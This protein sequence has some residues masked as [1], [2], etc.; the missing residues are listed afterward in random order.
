MAVFLTTRRA[1]LAA[2]GALA[3]C[4]P[5]AEFKGVDITGADYARQLALPDAD[6]KTRT[7]ADWKGKAVV[8]FF[9]FTQC[10]D[11]CPT[12]LQEVAEVKRRL[13]ADGD[14]LQAVF[15]T[16]DPERDTPEV[17]KGYMANF[18]KDFVALRGTP[19]E[20]KAAA[21]Q[22]KIYYAKSPGKAEGSYSMDHTAAS[23]LFDPQ[24][25]ARVFVRYGTGADAL[26][27]DVRLL[28]KGA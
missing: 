26:E 15:V 12:T 5:Q 23:F 2:A 22:F 27:N 13:G 17:L 6:G 21:Q 18:G 19:E 11:V 25:R 10:P 14:K 1:L 16:V 9:G 28:L 7:L 3:A 24:G 20:T 8:V 4:T